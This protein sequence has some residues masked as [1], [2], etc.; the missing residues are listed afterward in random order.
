MKKEAESRRDM[1]GNSISENILLYDDTACLDLFVSILKESQSA[2]EWGNK[3]AS[4]GDEAGNHNELAYMRY[5]IFPYLVEE[6]DQK[7]ILRTML[8]LIVL[9]YKRT[10]YWGDYDEDEAFNHKFWNPKYDEQASYL[11]SPALAAVENET[12]EFLRNDIMRFIH[13][14]I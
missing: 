9:A 3:I 8:K 14:C 5:H 1:R 7:D 10:V 6:L 4:Y 2:E 13:S 12:W 11:C